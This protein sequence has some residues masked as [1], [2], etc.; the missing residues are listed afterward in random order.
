MPFLFAIEIGFQLPVVLFTAYRYSKGKTT[1]GGHE[2][3]LL[4]YAF[5]T[6]FSTAL[7]MTHAFYIDPKDFSLEQR[8]AF[9]YQLMAPWVAVRKSR[10]LW[11]CLLRVPMLK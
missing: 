9:L 6:S 2:L 4:V 7:C 1:T 3:L 5:E 11:S 10:S 8:D